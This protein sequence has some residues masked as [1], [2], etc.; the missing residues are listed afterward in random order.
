MSDKCCNVVRYLVGPTGPTGPGAIGPI[1]ISGATGPIGPTGPT[2]KGC[3]GP[4]GP[5]GPTGPKTF[6]IDHPL[7]SDKYLVHACLEGP[8]AGVYYRGVGEIT[9]GHS[10]SITLPDYVDAFASDFNIQVTGIYDGTKIRVY[11][12]SLVSKGSFTVY[13]EN[14]AFHWLVIGSRGMIDVEPNK[15]DV[16]VKGEGPYLWI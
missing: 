6:V 4:P 10:V 12:V 15:S 2:G 9:N 16:V 13:G 3:I 7:D 1:G 8:E 11:N 14:G 5:V